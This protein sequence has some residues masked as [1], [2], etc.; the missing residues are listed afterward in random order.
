MEA[1]KRKL[2][3]A[4]ASEFSGAKVVLTQSKPTDRIT[5]EIVW[6]GFSGIEHIDR[7]RRLRKVIDS[8]L[9]TDEK[10]SVSLILTLTPQE[11][12]V[13]SGSSED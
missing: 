12:A 1:L 10:A 4:L 13:M 9:D 6:K 2:R 3:Q 7:Q 11:D 8:T 5:G